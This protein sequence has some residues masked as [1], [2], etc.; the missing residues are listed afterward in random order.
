MTAVVLRVV[1]ISL[2]L[3]TGCLEDQR[4]YSDAWNNAELH[5]ICMSGDRIYKLP[6]GSYHLYLQRAKVNPETLCQ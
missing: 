5:K 4:A 6:D 2:L 1:I 3:L